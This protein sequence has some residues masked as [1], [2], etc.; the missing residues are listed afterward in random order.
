MSGIRSS[1]VRVISGFKV[2]PEIVKRGDRFSGEIPGLEKMKNQDILNTMQ[3]D[4]ERRR[5]GRWRGRE[6]EEKRGVERGTEGVTER[7][8]DV[9]NGQIFYDIEEDY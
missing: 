2:G 4:R 5:E 1:V 6:G 7:K 8:K 9:L 3:T